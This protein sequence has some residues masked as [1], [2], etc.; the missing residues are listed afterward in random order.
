MEINSQFPFLNT[1]LIVNNDFVEMRSLGALVTLTR[2]A[3]SVWIRQEKKVFMRNF[4]SNLT[5]ISTI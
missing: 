3:M 4:E 2:R 1:A 5:K